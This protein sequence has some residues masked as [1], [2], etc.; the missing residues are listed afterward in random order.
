MNK[1]LKWMLTTLLAMSLAF[2]GCRPKVRQSDVNSVIVTPKTFSMSGAG[3]TPD[4]WWTVLGDA[5]LNKLIDTALQDNLD[6]IATW[7]RLAEARAAAVRADAGLYP[8]LTGTGAASRTRTETH[9]GPGGIGAP[10]GTT[11]A[12]S[13]SLGLAAAYEADLWGRVRSTSDAGRLDVL[14]SR[15]DLDAAAITLTAEVAETWYRLIESRRQL[16]LLDSQIETSKQILELVELRFGLG[17]VPAIDLLQQKQQL[18][19]KR[20]EKVR[21]YSAVK[22]LEHQ[23]AV[24]LGKA[25]GAFKAAGGVLP[26]KLPD[27]PETGLSA[28]L[29][30]RRPD[31][32][33]AHYRVAAAN[34]RVAAA[35]ADRFPRVS[36]SL[37]SSTSTTRVRD[38]FDNWFA[39]LAANLT[40]P[41]LDGGSRAAE[42][43]RTKA[44][45]SRQLHAYAQ[46]ILKAIKEVEDALVRESRQR[47]YIDSLGK[48]LVF[49]ADVIAKTRQRYANGD[50]AVDYLRILAALESHQRLE[51]TILQARRELIDFRIGLYRALAGNAA[52][53]ANTAG[54]ANEHEVEK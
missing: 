33:S 51:R 26:N 45:A 27:L 22:V 4:K 35:I 43:D 46:K 53:K 16:A 18:E 12:S 52:R 48:Q 13:F 23:L 21:T 20:A 9:K 49:A 41:I 19:S 37:Q 6:L 8:S 32:R 31:V 40:A 36:L 25:P 10:L 42:V 44:V 7:D 47:E 50:K 3:K 14:V 24:L 11:Y 2:C 54:E 38:L 1:P 34:K 15:E 30:R 39:T 5:E 28:D 17:K 29:I